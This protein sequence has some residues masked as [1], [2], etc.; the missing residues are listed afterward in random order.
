MGVGVLDRATPSQGEAPC[1]KVYT[2]LGDG[3]VARQQALDQPHTGGAIE[4]FD[5]QV[6]RCLG[7]AG[8]VCVAREVGFEWLRP[9]GMPFLQAPVEGSKAGRSDDGVCACASGTTELAVGKSAQN[10][11][12]VRAGPLCRCDGRGREKGGV[13]H[14]RNIRRVCA[15]RWPSR[16]ITMSMSQFPRAGRST[17]PLSCPGP[18]KVMAML[19][20]GRFS[21][22]RTSSTVA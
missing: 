15:K 18:T 16:S 2:G 11:A 17:V 14:S 6:E 9:A 4:T 5:Q 20:G 1:R 12:A 19:S 8:G 10:L 21:A 22:G 13:G 7:P 3:R